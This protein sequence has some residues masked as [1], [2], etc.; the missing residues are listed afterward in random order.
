[1]RES[2]L[3]PDVPLAFS[4]IILYLVVSHAG[5]KH[6]GTKSASIPPPHKSSIDA[7]EKYSSSNHAITIWFACKLRQAAGQVHQLFV[8]NLASVSD[9]AESIMAE[10]IHEGN[11]GVLAIILRVHRSMLVPAGHC[12]SVPAMQLLQCAVRLHQLYSLLSSRR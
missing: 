10:S 11:D 5:T 2:L 6:A 7:A 4:R 1:M 3:V 12:R 9:D 8:S